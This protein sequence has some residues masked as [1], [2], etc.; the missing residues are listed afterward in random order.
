VSGIHQNSSFGAGSS[1]SITKAC[2]W[3]D[4]VRTDL[5]DSDKVESIAIAVSGAV[6]GI[7]IAVSGGSVYVA[8]NYYGNT[9]N[10]STAY[11][12]KDG[13]KTDLPHPGNAGGCFAITVS[14]GSVYVAGAYSMNDNSTTGCYWKDGVRTDLQETNSCAYAVFVTE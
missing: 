12:W 3:R 5:P 10:N 9:I 1:T 8:G 2:Y 11:Y 13:V 7:D 6:S 14:G 4:G